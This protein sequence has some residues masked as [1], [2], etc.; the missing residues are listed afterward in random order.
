MHGRTTAAWTPRPPVG[1]AGRTLPPD[2]AHRAHPSWAE[3]G[4]ARGPAPLCPGGPC[5]TPA[6]RGRHTTARPPTLA[7]TGVHRYRNH[8]RKERRLIQAL[9]QAGKTSESRAQGA[10]TCG[11]TRMPRGPSSSL[12]CIMTDRPRGLPL[13]LP[14]RHVWR[15]WGCG[16]SAVD[17]PCEKR[18]HD[19]KLATS[20]RHCY[21][22]SAS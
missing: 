14:T 6:L 1:H 13:G 3:T 17:G 4:P 9:R 18:L 2:D 19:E 20:S 8:A 16:D 22:P 15:P 21:P 11:T 12:P 5:G 10:A 7:G